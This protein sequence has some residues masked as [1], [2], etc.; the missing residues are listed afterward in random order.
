MTSKKWMF[1]EQQENA[2]RKQE[3]EET[4]IKQTEKE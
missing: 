3:N 1:P 4:D 2:Q